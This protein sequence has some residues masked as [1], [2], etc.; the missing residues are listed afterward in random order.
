MPAPQATPTTPLTRGDAAYTRLTS[1][2]TCAGRRR[3]LVEVEEE[4]RGRCLDCGTELMVPLATEQ[5]SRLVVVG[6][7][8]QGIL[9]LD[10]DD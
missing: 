9:E 2:P 10:P 7:A 8:G 6:R 5:S 3:V 1:C 4:L